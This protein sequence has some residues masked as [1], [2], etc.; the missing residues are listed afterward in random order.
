LP[1]TRRSRST[2]RCIRREPVTAVLVAA[3]IGAALMLLANA[4][5]WPRTSRAW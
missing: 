1:S 3:G 2:L 5:T 4:V